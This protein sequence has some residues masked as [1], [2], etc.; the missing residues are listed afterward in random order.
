MNLKNWNFFRI[1]RLVLGVAIIVQA[2]IAKDVLMGLLGTMFT[3][4]PLF[5][6]GC[7]GVNTCSPIE[8]KSNSSKI[9]YEE[10]I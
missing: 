9:E 10:V 8:R 3:A 7:C 4:M 1:I 5:N 2:I 6:I